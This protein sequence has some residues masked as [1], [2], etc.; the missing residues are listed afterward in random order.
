MKSNYFHICLLILIMGIAS[1]SQDEGEK[2][3]P[4]EVRVDQAISDLKSELIGPSKGW[5]L[6]YQPTNES[7]V[8]FMIMDFSEDGLVNIKSDAAENDEEF[9]DHTIPW[10]IDNAL[11]LE[12]ILE[13]YGIFH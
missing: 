5:K 1:C 6:E 9:F 7:G 2:L 12:L 10:R 13:T 3:A 4:A 8:Y 11:G